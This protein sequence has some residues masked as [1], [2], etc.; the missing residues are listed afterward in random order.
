MAPLRMRD[1][2]SVE[3]DASAWPMYPS[4]VTADLEGRLAGVMP[5]A[6]RT[7]PLARDVGAISRDRVFVRLT[8]QVC[9]RRE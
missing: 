2:L 5:V 8:Y 1:Q 7:A 3:V 6:T 9:G 4:V